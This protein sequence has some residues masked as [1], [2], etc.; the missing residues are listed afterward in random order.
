MAYP[1]YLKIGNW[2]FKHIKPDPFMQKDSPVG[3][4]IPENLYLAVSSFGGNLNLTRDLRTYEGLMS[5]GCSV[6]S[7][8]ELLRLVK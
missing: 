7:D 1:N 3:G 5:Y 8:E 2:L 6:P 4:P